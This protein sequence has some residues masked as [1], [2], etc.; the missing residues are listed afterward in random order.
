MSL[1]QQGQQGPLSLVVNG[2]ARELPGLAAGS[3]VRDLL[4]A[5]GLATA[6]VA[7]AVNREVVPR[8]AFGQQPLATGDCVEILEAVGG[9]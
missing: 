8:S 3:C 2:E 6:R 9:G 1:P 4:A 5:L 7:V